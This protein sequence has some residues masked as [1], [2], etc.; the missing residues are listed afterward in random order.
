VKHTLLK[1]EFLQSVSEP[2]L[3]CYHYFVQFK[4]KMVCVILDEVDSTELDE[5]DEV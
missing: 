3:Q 1:L 4:Y 2:S 5:E